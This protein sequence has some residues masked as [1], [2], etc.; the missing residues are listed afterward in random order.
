MRGYAQTSDYMKKNLRQSEAEDDPIV[1]MD[2]GKVNQ[3]SPS[4]RP[5]K[6]WKN[7]IS[8]ECEESNEEGEKSTGPLMI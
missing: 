6:A 4:H 2:I 8:Y 7:S 3:K 5:E 1:D